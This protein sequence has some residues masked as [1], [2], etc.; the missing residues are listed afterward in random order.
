MSRE[1]DF[2]RLIVWQKSIDLA[3]AIIKISREIKK[4]HGF[5]RY[6]EQ[7]S[8]SALSVSSNIAEGKGRGS[9]KAYRLHIEYARA[10][11]YEVLS[12]MSVGFRQGWIEPIQYSSI[13]E[14]SLEIIKMLNALRTSLLPNS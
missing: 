4:E 1:F 11:L 7:L 8:S 14:Q 13:R 6:I 9:R 2:E 10:S 5:F 3:C 12:I